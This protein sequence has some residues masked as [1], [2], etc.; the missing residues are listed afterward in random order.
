LVVDGVVIPSSNLEAGAAIGESNVIARG[1]MAGL[2]PNDIESIEILKDTSAAIYGLNAGN[3]VI[4]ITT[5]K[6]KEG[7][8]NIN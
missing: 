6:G 1:N 3:C 5:K 4:L 2:N 7:T 8:L